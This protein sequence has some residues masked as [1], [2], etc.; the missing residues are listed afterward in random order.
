MHHNLAPPFPQL[1]TKLP[2]KP[3]FAP[4][5]SVPFCP[6]HFVPYHFVLEPSI[7]YNAKVQW[8]HFFFQN[9]L[10]IF[11]GFLVFEIC[12]GIFWPSMSTMRDRYVPEAS[13][14]F[15]VLLS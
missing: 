14:S 12:V 11:S 10:V 13:K 4:P 9:Q 5:L 15:R 2:L 7:G 3:S 6:Y 1:L 8:N